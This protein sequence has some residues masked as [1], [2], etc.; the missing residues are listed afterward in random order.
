MGG[1]IN[2]MS[3]TVGLGDASFKV[4]TDKKLSSLRDE[5]WTKLCAE[6]KAHSGRDLKLSPRKKELVLDF[7]FDNASDFSKKLANG[8]Y[9]SILF[10][11]LGHVLKRCAE[12]AGALR[13]SRS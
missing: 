8:V 4:I 3:T 13:N 11:S 1:Y 6:F 2:H 12:D 10:G 5:R 7:W 9:D